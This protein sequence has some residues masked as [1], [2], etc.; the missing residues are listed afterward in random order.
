MSEA[1]AVRWR[2][3]CDPIVDRLLSEQL[4][5][6][7]WN[8]D[9]PPSTRASFHSTIHWKACSNTNGDRALM[10]AAAEVEQRLRRRS[11]AVVVK[12]SR[13]TGQR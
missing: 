11:C 4:A 3:R 7:G 6:G 10:I 12:R 9:A 13:A 2:E 1:S 5:D 8:C